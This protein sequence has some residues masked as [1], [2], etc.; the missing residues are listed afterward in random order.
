MERE[1]EWEEQTEHIQFEIE[2]I[3]LKAQITKFVW[4]GLKCHCHISKCINQNTHTHVPKKNE[5]FALRS[6]V[7]FWF[8]LCSN[9]NWI[10]LEQLHGKSE[11]KVRKP[12]KRELQFDQ[13]ISMLHVTQQIANSMMNKNRRR[14]M[15]TEPKKNWT[16][17]VQLQLFNSA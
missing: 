12:K 8:E 7:Y 10:P 16:T 4:S 6:R 3:F 2:H 9:Q 13:R 15:R 5:V 14:R 17:T 11:R 1:R